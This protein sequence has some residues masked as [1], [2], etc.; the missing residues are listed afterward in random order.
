MNDSSRSPA[1]PPSNDEAPA[2]PDRLDS[3]AQLARA[4]LVI[5]GLGVGIIVLGAPVRD[6]LHEDVRLTWVEALGRDSVSLWPAG[7]VER[8][9]SSHKAVR[10]EFVPG[11]RRLV[12]ALAEP[13]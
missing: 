2:A 9:S 11:L 7:R 10:T 4:C 6:L 3:A 13:Q 1:S 5:A 12:P 8:V